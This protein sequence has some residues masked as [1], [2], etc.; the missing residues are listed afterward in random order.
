[1]AAPLLAG[2]G[3]P[4]VGFTPAAVHSYAFVARLPYGLSGSLVFGSVHSWL[5]RSG[6]GAAYSV[7]NSLASLTATRRLPPRP[8]SHPSNR[9]IGI[10]R[11][12]TAW[13]CRNG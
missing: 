13:L 5:L 8:R 9:R 4:F 7:A 10:H 1:M 11:A 2:F 6:L 3:S 12:A